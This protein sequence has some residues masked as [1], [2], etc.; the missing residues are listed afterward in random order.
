MSKD[1]LAG[2][3]VI[4]LAALDHLEACL[5]GCY[6]QHEINVIRAFLLEPWLPMET[7]PKDGTRFLGLVDNQVR[8]V[9]YGKTSHIPIYGFCLA[10]QGIEDYDLCEP[11][12]WMP[13]PPVI[14]G[15]PE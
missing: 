7:A 4:A 1:E 15:Q 2:D 5:D 8:F 13:L 3:R 9:S 14:V 11:T 6:A 10:D 12:G